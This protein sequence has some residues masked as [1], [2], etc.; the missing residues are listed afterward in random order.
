MFHS[1][2]FTFLKFYKWYQIAQN[3]TNVFGLSPKKWPILHSKFYAGYKY[4]DHTQ[5]FFI[6]LST[7]SHLKD[8]DLRCW[9]SKLIRALGHLRYNSVNP[10]EY[11]LL[12]RV[13]ALFLYDLIFIVLDYAFRWFNFYL[14]FLA[15]NT[16]KK[17][18]SSS[19]TT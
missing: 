11:N 12:C 14:D 7:L 17:P 15:Q 4:P 3:I 8:L 9:I 1:R 6:V 18:A 16:I 2:N 5:K 13:R 19:V 10:T